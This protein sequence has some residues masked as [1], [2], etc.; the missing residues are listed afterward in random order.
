MLLLVNDSCD[1]CVSCEP[2]KLDE[3]EC[4]FGSGTDCGMNASQDTC[5]SVTAP[6]KY[7][8]DGPNGPSRSG[9]NGVSGSSPSGS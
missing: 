8:T 1:K 7:A 3:I 2:D 4:A 5:G 9:E 6:G